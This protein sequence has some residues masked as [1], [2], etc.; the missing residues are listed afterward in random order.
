MTHKQQYTSSARSI[1]YVTHS[2]ATGKMVSQALFAIPAHQTILKVVLKF[3]SGSSDVGYL[4]L[5]N[6]FNRFLYKPASMAVKF[7]LTV[8][9]FHAIPK[10]VSSITAQ[11]A[12]NGWDIVS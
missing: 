10:V 11:A 1:R 4:R 7:S 12:N 9:V 2:F 3:F 8:L 5:L 6:G